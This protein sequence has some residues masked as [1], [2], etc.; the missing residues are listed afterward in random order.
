MVVLVNLTISAE[1]G[2]KA[3]ASYFVLEPRIRKPPHFR[4]L[5]GVIVLKGGF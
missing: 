5:H 2:R 4:D 1:F 3:G